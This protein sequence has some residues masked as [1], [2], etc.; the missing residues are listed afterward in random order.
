MATFELSMHVDHYRDWGIKEGVREIFTNA[1]DAERD[2]YVMT[3]KYDPDRR[4]IKINSEGAMLERSSLL[5][6]K[7]DKA[8]RGDQVG[9][10]GEGYKCGT[11]DCF[12]VERMFP[13]SIAT[14]T[15]NG[16]RLFAIPRS[17]MIM[18]WPLRW[19]GVSL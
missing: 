8:D 17:T 5:I 14:R 10:F 3:F 6:G 16:M 19:S 15:R 18:S 1:V 12:A 4:R 9:Q 13:F 2:G 11:L 7:S